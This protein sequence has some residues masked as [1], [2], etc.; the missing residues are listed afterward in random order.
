MS[1]PS[2]SLRADLG[3][4]HALI[5]AERAARLKAEARAARAEAINTSTDAYI[6]HLKLQIE[7]LRRA[8]HGPRSERKLRLLHQLELEEAEASASEDERKAEQAAAR[9]QKVSAFMRRHP[10]RKPFPGHLPRE[11]VVIT[12]PTSCPCCGNVV[13][14][15]IRAMGIRDKPITLGSPGRTALQKG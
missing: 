5:L 10:T 14:R 12:A 9:T 11:R 4:A 13:L 15:R 3:A 8:L 2:E 7:K 6:V 1:T